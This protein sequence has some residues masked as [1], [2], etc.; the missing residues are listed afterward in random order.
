[1]AAANPRARLVLL[2]QLNHVL[3]RVKTDERSANLAAYTDEALP[4]ADG[5]ARPIAEFVMSNR[6]GPR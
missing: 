3:K 4:L 1:M 2:P 5:V 6:G